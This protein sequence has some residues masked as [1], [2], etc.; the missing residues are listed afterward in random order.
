MDLLLLTLTIVSL[1]AALGFGAVAWR[2]LREERRRSQA[3]VAALAAAIDAGAPRASHPAPA[4]GRVEPVAVGTLFA[5]EPSAAVQG[6]PRVKIAVGAVM[7]AV[8][9]AALAVANR[10]S[11]PS[12]SNQS[13]AAAARGATA[14][15]PLEL[16]SMG[17]TRVGETLTVTGLVR[18]PHAGGDVSRI[19]AVVLAY[20]RA[21]ALVAT[22]RAPLDITTLAPGDESPF[23]VRIP[24][25][26]EVA[27]YRVSFRT[28]RGIVRHID[29]R[30]DQMRL[31]AAIH[32][33]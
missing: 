10:P 5:A 4:G 32:P 23:V 15:A 30:G 25:V 6:S 18:N 14:D 33:Q 19:S 16:V 7:A 9:I 26:A 27:R 20:N 12:R 17:H 13:A 29:R 24:G 11:T 21:G 8:V 2:L 28:E 31:V 22:G 3:R 1:V